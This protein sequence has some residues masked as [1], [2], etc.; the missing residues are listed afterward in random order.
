MRW[1]QHWIDVLFLH[2]PATP[3]QLQ[4]LLPA[5]LEID[6]FENQAW[7]SYVLFRLQLRPAWLPFV[8]G[9]ASL[10]ELN[11]RTYVRYRGQPGIYFLAMY[12]DNALAIAAS[13][14]L[15]PLTYHPA[16]LTYEQ[17]S[18]GWWRAEC[19]AS[20]MPAIRLAL[21]F[22]PVAEA[23]VAR[24]CSLD[25]WIL[26]RY[27]L[28]VNRPSGALV[29]AE[30]EHAPWTASAVALNIL[31]HA[32]DGSLGPSLTRQPAFARF[33]SGVAA[34]FNPFHEVATASSLKPAAAPPLDR[35][36]VP[37]VAQ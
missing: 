26:E 31:Q 27:R 6:T 37:H 36:V 11:V 30:V 12:A 8:P 14:L 9:F 21:E 7:I 3:A 19:H 16:R 22:R 17:T 18:R 13:R 33:S 4:A 20:D 28:F 24:P 5:H 35:A 34:Q 23:A 32:F 10:T 15:T 1:S 29:A 2:F 25:A